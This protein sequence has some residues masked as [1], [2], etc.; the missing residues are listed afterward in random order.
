MIQINVSLRDA[1]REVI[2]CDDAGVNL[3]NN[4]HSPNALIGIA[5]DAN[6]RQSVHSAAKPNALIG[7][8]KGR[9]SQGRQSLSNANQCIR[10][11]RV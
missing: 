4:K 3:N 8:A 5:K 6:Q 1:E 7:V 2:S 10:L 9:R 11:L